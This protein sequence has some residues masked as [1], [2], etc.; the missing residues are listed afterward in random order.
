MEAHLLPSHEGKGP[1]RPPR[2]LYKLHEVLRT[3]VIYTSVEDP[4]LAAVCILCFQNE[5]LTRSLGRRVP[6]WNLA[7]SALGKL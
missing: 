5:V 4:C 7:S 2:Q 1:S 6:L 3:S